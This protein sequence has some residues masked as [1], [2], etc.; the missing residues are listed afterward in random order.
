MLKFETKSKYWQ[1]FIFTQKLRQTTIELVI[2]LHNCVVVCDIK[3]IYI[4][5]YGKAPESKAFF[6]P[7]IETGKKRESKS[8]NISSGLDSLNKKAGVRRD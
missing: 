5:R 8:V 7:D 4:R 2:G 6:G 3:N 1:S